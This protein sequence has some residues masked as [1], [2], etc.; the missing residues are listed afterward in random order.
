MCEPTL[1]NLRTGQQVCS[2]RGHHDDSSLP[3]H[4]QNR[5]SFGQNGLGFAIFVRIRVHR[6]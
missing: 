1:A 2:W 3:K 5:K 6:V 4:K